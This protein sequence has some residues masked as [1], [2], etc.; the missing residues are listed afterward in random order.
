MKRADFFIIGGQK[1][2]TTSL[3]HYIKDHPEICVSDPKEVIF[4]TEDET[5]KKGINYFEDFF[6]GCDESKT[7][8][9]ADVHLLVSSKAPE[10]LYNYNPNAKL[11]LCVREPVERAFSAYLMGV[12]DGWETEQ[13]SFEDAIM[14]EEERVKQARSMNKY[15]LGYVNNGLYAKHIKRWLT[16]FD[17]DQI[18]LLNFHDFKENTEATVKRTYEFLEVRTD[19]E[20]DTSTKYNIM[21]SPRFSWVN[22]LLRGK[23]KHIR[24]AVGGLLPSTIKRN[25]T[26]PLLQKIYKWNNVPV[27]HQPRLDQAVRERIEPFFEEDIEQLNREFGI[28]LTIKGKEG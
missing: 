11:I 2:G 6:K 15:H 9:T 7:I 13:I 22:S 10:R 14:K 12:R 16:Y 25:L 26:R 27:R 19:F 28:N 24:R 5:Y 8:G 17:K 4:F 20:P 23:G 1:C 18:L 3:F 21:A